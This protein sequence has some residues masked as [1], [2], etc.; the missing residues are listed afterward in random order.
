[1]QKYSLAIFCIQKKFEKESSILGVQMGGVLAGI[2][3]EFFSPT[4]IN[5]YHKFEKYFI[6]VKS[7]IFICIIKK[8]SQE[9]IRDLIEFAK[10]ESESECR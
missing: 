3:L 10:V 2:L 1:M 7:Y 4:I 5:T 9:K 8:I 6:F